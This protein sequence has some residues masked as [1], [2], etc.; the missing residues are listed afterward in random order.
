MIVLIFNFYCSYIIHGLSLHKKLIFYV[1]KIFSENA[2]T[3]L[4][5]NYSCLNKTLFNGNRIEYVYVQ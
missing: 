2:N 5:I 1:T 3:N 4:K